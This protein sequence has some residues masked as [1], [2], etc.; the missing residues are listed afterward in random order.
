MTE[1]NDVLE[2]LNNQIPLQEK[3]VVAHNSLSELFPFIARI[4][5]AIYDTE[6]GILKTYLHSSGDDH[7]LENYQAL[8]DDA[9]SLKSILEKG[10]P[11]VINCDFNRSTQHFILYTKK[12]ECCKWLTEHE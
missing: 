3:L 8:L 5:I 1:H 10:V 12:K 11:R 6:T 2:Q 4:A 7:P 9:P